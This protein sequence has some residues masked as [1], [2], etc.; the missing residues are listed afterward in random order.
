MPAGL[1]DRMVE[2][3]FPG[4]YWNPTRW[5]TADGYIPFRVFDLYAA[6]LATAAA[7][8]RMNLAHAI[9]LALVSDKTVSDRLWQAAI[10]EAYP[11]EG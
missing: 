1:I 11:R 10:H 4:V 7:L 3:R 9:G 5:P 2:A 6:S 8:D